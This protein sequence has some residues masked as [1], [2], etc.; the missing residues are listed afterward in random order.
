[1]APPSWRAVLQG[2]AGSR[3][4]HGHGAHNRTSLLRYLFPHAN[5][6]Q[7]TARARNRLYNFR[8]WF[9]PTLKT[10]IQGRIYRYLVARQ[11]RKKLR[12]PRVVSNPGGRAP[13]FWRHRYLKDGTGQQKAR[14]KAKMAYSG[15]QSSGYGDLSSL[16][17]EGR[18]PGA[19]RK[20]IAGYLKAANELRQSYFNQEGDGYNTR[21]GL[22]ESGVEGP[23][24]FPE[25][26]VVR[27]GNEEMI[28]FPSYARRHV[29]R[30]RAPPPATGDVSEEDYWRR[31]WEQH[32]DD[33]AIVDVDVRGWIYTP[34]RG[35]STRKQRLMI[36]LARQLAGLP[37]AAPATGRPG[38]SLHSSQAS[39]RTS[40]PYH[41]KQEEDLI[42]LEADNIVRKG[43]HEQRYARR[44]AFSETPAHDRDGDSVYNY[45]SATSSRDPSPDRGRNRLS[46]ISTTSSTDGD[47]GTITPPQKRTSWQQPTKMTAAELAI[48]NKHLLNRITP[49]MHNPLVNSSISCFFYNESSSRQ[50]TVFTNPS[51]HF[52]CRAPL[53][54]VPTHVRVLAGE[55][56]SATEEVIVTSPKGVS[57]ISDIDDT[58]KHSAI[59][60]GAREIFRNAFVKELGDLTI[61]GVREW[62]NTMHDMGVQLHY[63]SNSPWQMYPVLTSFFKMAHLPKGSFH[64]KQYS[65][66]LQGIFEPVAER[67]KSSLDKIMSDFPDRKFI[68]VGDSGEADLE[69]YTEVALDNP[70]RVLG[71]FIRDVTTPVKAGYFD[72]PWNGTSG[73]GRYGSREPHRQKTG[74]SLAQSKRLS[75]PGDIRDDDAD[76]R[77]AIRASLVDMEE[78]TRHAKNSV[79]PDA[80]SPENATSPK[81]GPSLP[82]RRSD[83]T[84]TQSPVV[85]S[86]EE[87]LIDFSD[88]PAPAQQWLASPARSGSSL[89]LSQGN[90]QAQLKPSPA[91]PPK[92]PALRSPSPSGREQTGPPEGSSKTPPPRPRKPSSAVKA[93]SAQ[94]VRDW[95]AR[96]SPSQQTP[97]QT[98]QPSPLSQVTHQ[99]PEAKAKPPLPARRK[100]ESMLLKGFAS[101]Q[102]AFSPSTYWQSDAAVGQPRSSSSYT[103]TPRAMSTASTKSMDELRPSSSST[104]R[105]APPRPPPRVRNTTSYSTTATRK[106]TNRLSGAWDDGSGGSLPGTPSEAGM[107]RKEFLWNQRWAR[108]KA[109]LEKQGVTLRTWRIGADV[110]DICVRLAEQA[111]REIEKESKRNNTG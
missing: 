1:M 19:R 105:A 87:D 25:A 14:Q 9:L 72:N 109:V 32:Q 37:A 86:P 26:A 30:K 58:V 106:T 56:L 27:R 41:D 107:S 102:K 52:S 91:P 108:A 92:P 62:Y 81:P 33:N 31:E 77:A 55:K 8:Y 29:K 54:F 101:T 60:S 63:V 96:P 50:H 6:H 68:L 7:R 53:D 97:T 22:G 95:S 23:G 99:S 104:V 43:E 10:N 34:N 88:E 49:F 67:K 46:Q 36:G 35:Q 70:G 16:R 13:T 93:P 111:F 82:S 74:D 73:G 47:S 79:N 18:E 2:I 76:L 110:A 28:L 85:A 39:S 59:G 69:V 65:G 45:S 42:T 44:G 12:V 48:A 57:L 11:D 78:E 64:L 21:D 66:Y 80:P 98:H 103:E 20:K 15:A 100:Q 89:R 38:E 40:S 51:G 24:G 75:R 94:Q 4:R 90:G 83:R 61:D 17:S 3:S 5:V 84:A 71:I